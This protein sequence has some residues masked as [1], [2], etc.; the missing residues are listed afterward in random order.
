MSVTLLY[1]RAL[2]GIDAPLVQVETH[3]SPGLPG[4]SIVGLPEAAVRE[5]RDRVRSAL[6]NSGFEFPV[7]RITVNLAPA[8][9][10]KGGGRYDLPIALGI[11]AASGQLR[12]PDPEALECLGELAL[13]G[14]LRPGQGILPAALAA[15][16]AGRALIL[17]ASNASEAALARGAVHGA[18]SL[19]AACSHIEGRE[20]IAAATAPALSATIGTTP[21]L[22]DVRGQPQARRALE[23]AAAGGHSLLLSGPPGSGKS[24]L[25]QRLPGLLPPL[26]NDA[27]L[28][29]AA[30]H[31]LHRSR[32]PGQFHL[33][34]FR[35]PHHTASAPALVGGGGTPRPGEISLAHH[36]VLFLDELPEFSR[37]VLEVLREPLETGEVHISRARSQAR[38]PAR[39]Q[40]IAAM[41][42]CPCGWLGDPARSCGYFCD[43]ARRYQQKLSGPLLDRIDLHL[44]VDAV[45]AAAIASPQQG[46][47]SAA[48][49]ERVIA[50]RQRQLHRQGL[51]N[52]QL[53]PAA[54][55]PW[56]HTHRDWLQHSMERLGLSARSLHRLLRVARTLADLADEDALQEHHLLEALSYR[57]ANPAPPV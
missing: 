52:S 20:I 27:A 51:L 14:E 39:F 48:V 44:D 18:D 40:L 55:S 57:P 2:L 16:R 36:G 29:V 32:D 1:T 45:S 54:L 56:L 49:R 23:L 37:H 35:S 9:L 26:D 17:P 50:A 34:P 33:P 38:F 4:F 24:M 46:E 43:K 47:T 22:S 3:L 7:R 10:P 25:A 19:L 15:Q 30:V 12:I 6:I 41:N 8:D 13:G 42:P 21:C 5:S 28:E 31:S 11:L 53:D